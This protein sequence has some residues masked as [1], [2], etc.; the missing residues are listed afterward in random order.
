M[1]DVPAILMATLHHLLAFTVFA[2]LLFEHLLFRKGL[3]LADAKRLQATDT[4]YGLAVVGLIAVGLVRVY[5]FG[6]GSAAYFASAA[7]WTKMIA[8]GVVGVLSAYPTVRFL[9]WM[10]LTN[11]GQT[12]EV[13]ELD[14]KLIPWLL[15]AELVGIVVIVVSAVTMAQP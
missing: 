3:T 15:R 7:F 1:D 10:K 9:S 14:A 2:S 8:F 6:K 11:A 5:F 4:M 13:T 12:P